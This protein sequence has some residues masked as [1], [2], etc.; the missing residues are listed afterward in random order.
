MNVSSLS[1]NVSYRYF[2]TAEL[3]GPAMA[4]AVKE[5][6]GELEARQSGIDGLDER[7]PIDD[8]NDARNGKLEVPG[9]GSASSAIGEDS[10]LGALKRAFGSD[11]LS[12]AEALGRGEAGM[13]LP[14]FSVQDR[15]GSAIGRAQ[16]ATGEGTWYHR[17]GMVGE[18]L[19]CSFVGG[20]LKGGITGCVEG[21]AVGKMMGGV[22]GDAIDNLTSGPSECRD[23]SSNGGTGGSGGANGSTRAGGEG[24]AGSSGGNVCVP[25]QSGTNGHTSHGMGDDQEGRDTKG[26]PTINGLELQRRA[27]NGDGAAA[28][29]L[30][31][32]GGSASDLVPAWT[33]NGDAR[34]GQGKG[35]HDGDKVRKGIQSIGQK[36]DSEN[37]SEPAGKVPSH[38]FA[39]SIAARAANPVINPMPV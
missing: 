15:L 38:S 7:T 3:D 32:R 31:A 1:N 36:T 9:H 39:A 24:A 37:G 26:D 10:E 11:I 4:D 30:A 12:E 21:G 13:G 20:Y 8:L 34:D 27:K 29:I 17:L 5:E 23:T 35:N 19:G 18:F 14:G 6:L 22:V 25:Q 16:G 28:T 33:V 2:D